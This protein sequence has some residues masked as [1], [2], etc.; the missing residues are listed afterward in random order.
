ML[1]IGS[2][3]TDLVTRTGHCLVSSGLRISQ[4]CLALSSSIFA[5]ALSQPSFYSGWV[6]A[7]HFVLVCLPVLGGLGEL[8][9]S[10]LAEMVMEGLRLDCLRILTLKTPSKKWSMDMN[11]SPGVS[12]FH[13]RIESHPVHSVLFGMSDKAHEVTR[14]CS[15]ST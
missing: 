5:I 6:M 3:S 1:R 15:I 10:R 13:Q 4:V 14:I 8:A 11:E 9:G 7:T 12:I 2:I